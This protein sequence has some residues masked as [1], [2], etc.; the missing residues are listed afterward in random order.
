MAARYRHIYSLWDPMKWYSYYRQDF[1]QN[2][3][4]A[5][6]IMAGQVGNITVNVV[7]NLMVGALGVGELA[8][9]SFSVSIYIIFLVVGM[10]ISFALPPLV[11]EADGAGN[12]REI[13]QFFKHSFV[14]NLGFAFFSLLM[15]ELAMPHLHFLGQDPEVVDLARPYLRISAWSMIP[16]MIFQSLRCYSD[17]MSATIHPMTAII[18]GNVFNILFNYMF[19]FGKFGAPQLGV[20][21]AALGTLLARSLICFILL[22]LLFRRNR[23]WVHLQAANF[24]VYQKRLFKRLL[25]LGIPSSM[26]MFFEVSAFAGASLL[27]GSISKDAQAA[28]QIAINLASIT[29]LICQGLAMAATVRVGNQLGQRNAEG[30][31]RAGFSA[32]IQVVL[33]MFVTALIFVIARDYLPT[34]YIAD[35]QVISLA[36]TLLILAAFFQIPDGVQ[37]AAL[38]VLRGLQD[39]KRPT[40]ITFIAYWIFGLPVSWLAA[41]NANLGPVGIW[42]GLVFGLTVSAILLTWRFNRKSALAPG[43]SQAID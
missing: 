34:L 9:V 29:F 23:L 24:R 36:A 10:G 32:I 40:L 37:V 5:L 11:S 14:L 8:S 43:D 35:Q 15:I 1:A 41:F 2:L 22:G 27:M 17:G 4:L 39:V 33:F 18:I 30:V 3:K 21:G 12:P 38:G 25:S 31:R 6:P 26:Q 20:E 19:I 28:H 16:F 7:D 42:I 13:S